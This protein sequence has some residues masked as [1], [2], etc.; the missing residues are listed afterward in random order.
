MVQHCLRIFFKSV[1]RHIVRMEK[2]YTAR[3]SKF[4]KLPKALSEKKTL[5]IRPYDIKCCL[6][7][8]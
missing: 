6:D 5:E 3:Q 4:V 2:L 7:H 8:F 1:T